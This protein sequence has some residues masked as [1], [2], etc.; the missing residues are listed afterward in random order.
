MDASHDSPDHGMV[1]GLKRVAAEAPAE[2]LTLGEL[3][4][5]LGER[6]FG[7]VLFVLALPVCLPFL[8]GVP[9]IVALPMLALSAQMALGRSAPWLPARMASRRLSKESLEKTARGAERWF[10]WIEDFATPRLAF[11][12]GR[13]AERVVGFMFCL[14]CLS[15]LVPLPLTNSTP[16]VALVVASLGLINRD[17]LL[18]LAGL[19]LGTAWIVVLYGGLII[20]GPA[21]VDLLTDLIRTVIREGFWAIAALGVLGLLGLA[22]LFFWRRSRRR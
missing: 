6:A 16:G 9:Q 7:M 2:G 10:G 19:L 12:S 3:S 17:G 13:I 14:F 11:L 18:V 5:A 4:G 22:G 15:V 8:Y 21:F 20:L 1:S